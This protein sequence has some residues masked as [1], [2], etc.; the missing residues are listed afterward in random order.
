MLRDGWSSA[1]SRAKDSEKL[2]KRSERNI[3]RIVL[4]ICN[5]TAGMD[6]E[7]SQIQTEFTRTT[8]TDIQSNAQVLCELLA[9]DMVDPKDAY[10]VAKNLFPDVEAAYLRGM[11]WYEQQQQ[12]LERQ[13]TNERVGTGRSSNPTTDKEGNQAV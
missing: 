8:L 11:K 10:Q 7:I 2:W 5:A 13:L 12:D 3:L 4:K 1:E 6:L 9:N